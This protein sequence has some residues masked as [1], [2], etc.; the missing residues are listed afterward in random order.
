MKTDYDVVIVGAGIVGAT[1][2][3]LLAQKQACSNLSVALVDAGQFQSRPLLDDFDARVVAVS[4][5]SRTIL[6]DIGAWPIIDSMRA[7]PYYEMSVWDG[8]GTGK[9][10]FDADAT[11]SQALGHICENSVVVSAL[12]SL[13]KTQGKSISLFFDQRLDAIEQQGAHHQLRFENGL[14]LKAGL[15]IGADGAHSKLRSLAGVST[16]EWDYQHKAIIT[17]VK[18]EKPHQ[19]CAWQRFSTQGP[20]AFLPLRKSQDDHNY[21]SIVWSVDSHKADD[22]MALKDDAFGT[23]L[24]REFEY[25]LGAVL[26]VDRRMAIPLR[27][28]FAKRYVQH[29][30][31]L[32]GDAAHTIHPLAG[33]GVNLGISDVDTLASEIERACLRGVAIEEPSTLRRYERKRQPQ[34]LVAMASMEAFKRGFSSDS[35]TV[36]WL[37]NWGLNT[38]DRHPLIKNVFSKVASGQVINE[39]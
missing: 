7:C 34:N 39:Q 14:C 33:Q 32:V 9:I 2:A 24:A 29:G 35:L 17:T 5:S 15:V 10:H 11:P 30:I 8:E 20:L 25:R 19:F 4:Q 1:L 36:K 3:A 21:C 22:L 38:V 18:T 6:N 26:K 16:S 23:A 27:Q 12:H 37:R 13:L 28:R 31:A